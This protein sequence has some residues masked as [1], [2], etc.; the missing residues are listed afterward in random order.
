MTPLAEL[1]AQLIQQYGLDR[2]D[3]DAL[4]GTAL[5]QSRAWLYAHT[6]HCLSVE[7]CHTLHRWAAR[8]QRGEPLAYILGHKEFYGLQLKVNEHTLVPRPETE[9]L[10][11]LIRAL[12]HPPTDILD[13]GTGSGAIA[14]A[15]ASVMRN[16]E[17]TACEQSA[18]ALA[19]AQ[20]NAAELGFERIN[21]VQ[22]HWFD[23]VPG[24]RFDAVVSNPPYID[25]QDPHLPALSHEPRSALI[26]SDSGLADL[27]AIIAAA[28]A[29]LRDGGLLLLEHGHRQQAQVM[30]AMQQRGYT[31]IQGH[32]DHAGLARAVSAH[33]H[34]A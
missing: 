31:H 2:L 9:L 11:D 15:L 21:F 8:R 17:I 23:A 5:K 3:C 34:G 28:P 7:Q 16:A 14:L 27:H 22:G 33:W 25:P 1:R 10:V 30:A 13:L 18:D 4:L 20:S 19:V 32:R 6:D 26:A 12:P 24:Q 29:H